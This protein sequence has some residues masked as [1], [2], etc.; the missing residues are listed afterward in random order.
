MINFHT[1]IEPRGRRMT[2]EKNAKIKNKK[3]ETS[4]YV[5]D[6]LTTKYYYNINYEEAR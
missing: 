2:D 3:V 1:T 5:S 6:K 4:K